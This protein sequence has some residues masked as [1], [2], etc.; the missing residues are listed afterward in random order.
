MQRILFCFPL[1]G[2]RRRVPVSPTIAGSR[3]ESPLNI[4]ERAESASVRALANAAG[5]FLA[6]VTVYAINP[7]SMRQTEG[8]TGVQ[9]RSVVVGH[10][11]ARPRDF[12]P[13]TPAELRRT[14]ASHR[15]FL[16]LRRFKL[17]TP[18]EIP[19]SRGN[20]LLTE[21]TKSRRSSGIEISSVFSEIA[22]SFEDS[23]RRVFELN[24]SSRNYSGKLIAHRVIV[25]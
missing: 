14:P 16:L 13:L 12:N 25:L 23:Q 7:A 8:T 5:F 22:T 3:G 10:G 24:K 21:R 1:R 11:V 9:T 18:V 15:S 4:Y 2:T 17:S 20:S 6:G 19:F